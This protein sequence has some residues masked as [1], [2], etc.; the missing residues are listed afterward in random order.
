MCDVCEDAMSAIS[1]NGDGATALAWERADAAIRAWRDANPSL[2]FAGVL[3][4][5]SAWAEHM[6]QKK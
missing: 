5:A 6:R 2:E 4:E 3:D 1:D